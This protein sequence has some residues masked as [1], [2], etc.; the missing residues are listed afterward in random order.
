MFYLQL[1]TKRARELLAILPASLLAT[2][3]P[4][5][6]SFKHDK[7]PFTMDQMAD[8]IIEIAPR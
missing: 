2:S 8:L 6:I 1:K 3:A 7:I 5:L 4:V